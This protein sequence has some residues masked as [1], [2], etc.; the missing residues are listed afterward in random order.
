MYAGIAGALGALT[1]QFVGPDSFSV[2]LSISLLVGVVVGGLASI[3]GAVYGALFIQFVPNLADDISK[4]A[5]SAIYGVVLIVL[6][7]VPDAIRSRGPR[8]QSHR[9][10]RGMEKRPEHRLRVTSRPHGAGY[11]RH[12]I[13]GGAM[14]PRG[15]HCRYC[16]WVPCVMRLVLFGCKQKDSMGEEGKA[17]AAAGVEAPGQRRDQDRADDALQRP[18]VGIRN[19][20]KGGGRVLQEDQQGGRDQRSSDKPPERRRRL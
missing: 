18:G 13:Q 5:P 20:R 2:F 3:S 9:R 4:A 12:A 8:T 15:C 6:S 16:S 11:T 7:R 1:V 17:G 10:A 14:K 19:H